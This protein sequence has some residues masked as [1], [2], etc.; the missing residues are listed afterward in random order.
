MEY[1]VAHF[2]RARIKS[3]AARQN[4]RWGNMQAT[5]VTVG[6]NCTFPTVGPFLRSL[7]PNPREPIQNETTIFPSAETTYQL[8]AFFNFAKEGKISASPSA[9]SFKMGINKMATATAILDTLFEF[10]PGSTALPT[11]NST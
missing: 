3:I 11:T 5:Q 4:L 6:C 10:Q 1:R 8:A 9:Q 7:T 2:F